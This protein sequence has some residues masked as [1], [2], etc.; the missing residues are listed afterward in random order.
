M[1]TPSQRTFLEKL[2]PGDAASF[3]QAQAVV[4]GSDASLLEGRP[5]GVVRPA[6]PE[7]V[8]ELMAWAQAER[9][10]IV[11]RGRAT[12]A[13]GGAVASRGGL[14][15]STLRLNRIIEISAEDFVAVTEP[16]VV[17]AELQKACAAR[18][19][20]YPPD[21]GSVNISTIGGNVATCAGGMRAVKYGVTRDWVLGLT[22]VLPGGQVVRCGG[23]CH[24]NVAG[25]DLTRLIVG[26]E[27]TLAL[28]TE[29]ILKLTPLPEASV[30]LLAGFA[31]MDALLAAASAVFRAGLLPTAMEFFD[32]GTMRALELTA[33][34]VPWPSVVDG[35]TQAAL[36]LRLDGSRAALAADLAALD[37]VLAAAG[38]TFREAAGDAPSEERLWELRR[39]VSP[40]LHKLGPDKLRDDIAVPRGSIARAVHAFHEI[41]ERL[42]VTVVCFGHLGDGNVHTD[43]MFDGSDRRQSDAAHRAK[44]E[45]LRAVASMGGT[46]T[47][48]HG[49]GLV[50]LPFLE[51]QLSRP[52]REL[53]RR[54][55]AAFDP[56][57]IMNPGKAF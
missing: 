19:L 39:L 2:F 4:H 5:W 38:T 48:E 27:G 3:G 23:R 36:L 56:Y 57:G 31:D 14:V 47:G 50:K 9:V 15:V 25:L 41:G 20:F 1:L 10:P 17:T 26:S 6:T 28:V 46:L 24:K 37:A 35:G 45:I 52:E 44:E 7:Q 51:L 13:V 34:A 49:V 42:G 21:P 11:A 33:P 43:V 8:T 40:A 29:I 30:S 12:G 54:V 22:A 32:K 18:R 53:M 55:K 16:G